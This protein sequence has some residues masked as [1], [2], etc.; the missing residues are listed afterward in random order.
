MD[1]KMH[2]S[3]HDPRHTLSHHGRTKEYLEGLDTLSV[4]FLPAVPI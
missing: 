3:S 2:L 1:K 4:L